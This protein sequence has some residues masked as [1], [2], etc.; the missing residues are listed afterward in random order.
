MCFNI[1]HSLAISQGKNGHQT[2]LCVNGDE[3]GKQGLSMNIFYN[4]IN[5]MVCKVAKKIC[6]LSVSVTSLQ[7]CYF[8]TSSSLSFLQPHSSLLREELVLHNFQWVLG[9]CQNW[10]GSQTLRKQ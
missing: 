5:K 8:L 1:W 9:W 3:G 2:T 7:Y 6:S 4:I 10:K